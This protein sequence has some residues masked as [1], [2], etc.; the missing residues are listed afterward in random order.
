MD[1]RLYC[2]NTRRRNKYLTYYA[3]VRQHVTLS[4]KAE[5][6]KWPRTVGSY[7]R[8][9]TH[10][11]NYSHIACIEATLYGTLYCP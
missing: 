7:A 3:V 2:G 1:D 8:Y 10:V 5:S 11:Y 9:H 4:L 6:T